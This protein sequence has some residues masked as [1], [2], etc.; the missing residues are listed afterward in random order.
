[1]LPEKDDMTNIDLKTVKSFGD[2]WSRFDQTA[3]SA[4]EAHKIFA[5]YFAVFPWGALPADAEGFDMGCGSGRWAQFVAP[6]VG[7]LHCIDPSAAIEVA[8]ANLGRFTNVIFHRASVDELDLPPASQDFGYSLGVLHHVPD[9]AAAIRS[10]V[11]LLKPGAPLLLYLYYAFENRPGWFRV[12]W[13]A[14]D[15]LR[16]MLH[17]LPPVLKHVVTDIIAATVYLPLARLSGALENVGIDVHGIP[18]SFYRHHSFYT[19]R[20]DA[21]DRFGTPLEQRFTRAYIET[22]MREAGLVNM[23]FSTG[24]PYWCA[25]GFK[26]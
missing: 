21:R 16:R 18:L 3:L 5:E 12:L 26:Q 2:E 1:V 10:C 4:E 22:M 23:Q 15:I 7:R 13:R 24:A 6:I 25:V 17:R 19:M 14:S 20:T 9:T 8:R 11:E